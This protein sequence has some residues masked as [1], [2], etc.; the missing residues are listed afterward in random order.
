MIYFPKIRKIFII[1]LVLSTFIACDDQ[2]D[3]IPN[4]RVLL[5]L[6][7]DAVRATLGINQARMIDNE[8]VNGILLFRLEEW[9]FNA[10]DRTCPF[11]P[12]DN[13][14]VDF[15]DTELKAVCPC[16]GSEFELFFSGHVQKGP[17]RRPLKQYR[18]VI[19]GNRLRITN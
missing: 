16:C 4:V 19:E 9:Q 7:L 10:F 11:Q 17:A 14:A 18:T 5:S 2:D 8:G 12:E 13:C 6:D 15:D 3:W 1:S